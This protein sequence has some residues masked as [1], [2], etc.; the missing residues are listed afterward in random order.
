MWPRSAPAPQPQSPPLLSKHAHQNIGHAP[1]SRR[2]PRPAARLRRSS[3]NRS[4]SSAARYALLSPRPRISWINLAA[5]HHDQPIAPNAAALPASNAVT[6]NVVSFVL[7]R[8]AFSLSAITLV[9]R[10]SGRAPAVLFVQQQQPPACAHGPA[11]NKR[12]APARCPPERLP[13][14][15]IQPI[16]QPHV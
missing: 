6:I 1:A 2:P 5:M 8:S 16:L 15:F 10:S 4:S 14:A 12:S 13:I 3:S 7:S 9:R 11:I